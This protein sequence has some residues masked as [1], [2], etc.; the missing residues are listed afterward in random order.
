MYCI[1]IWIKLFRNQTGLLFCFK[2]KIHSALLAPIRFHSFC[3]PLSFA[4]THCP[5]LRLIA[6][7]YHWMSLAVICC[8]S[9]YY[10][11]PLFVPLVVTRSHSLY[12]SLP[13]VVTRHFLSLLVPLLF[14]RC[15][16]LFHSLSL[17]V[18]RCTTRLSSL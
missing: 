16:S 15:H 18:F 6:T 14:T 12:H 5:S 4:S 3:H 17:I 8:H 10:S 1:K 13:F 7:R 9:F 2:T 11:L